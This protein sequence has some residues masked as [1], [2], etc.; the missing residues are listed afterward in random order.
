MIK[1]L[2]RFWS[3][4]LDRKPEQQPKRLPRKEKKKKKKYR[5]QQ[6]DID[7]QDKVKRRSKDKTQK[8]S[9]KIN[10]K[11]GAK[12]RNKLKACKI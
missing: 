3:W 9:R 7:A 4:L 1:L 2:K 11:G 10:S 8:R 12:S 6:S 5:L